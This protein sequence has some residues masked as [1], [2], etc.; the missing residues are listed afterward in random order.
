MTD[1]NR[2]QYVHILH[3]LSMLTAYYRSVNMDFLIYTKVT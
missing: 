3:Y 1:D 2:N